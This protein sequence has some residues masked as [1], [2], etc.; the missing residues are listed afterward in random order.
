MESDIPR[1]PGCIQGIVVAGLLFYATGTLAAAIAGGAIPELATGRWRMALLFILA[2]SL[3]AGIVA[4]LTRRN[5]GWAPTAGLAAGLF[6]IGGYL[7]LEVAIHALLNTPNLAALVRLA[8][9]SGYIVLLGSL[10]PFLAG[11]PRRSLGQSLAL[12]R[13]RASTFLL[14]LALT[15]LLTLPWPLT[16]ALGD[17]LT[18][19]ELA[20]QTL[21][22]AIPLLLLFWGLLFDLLTPAMPS[23]WMAAGLVIL[24]Y[25]GTA[26]AGRILPAGSWSE[27]P[28]SLLPFPLALLLTELRAREG[29]L[30]PLLPL[31]FAFRLAPLLFTDPRDILANGIPEPQHL[32]AYGIT[33]GGG[34]LLGLLLWGVRRLLLRVGRPPSSSLALGTA[35]PAALLTWTAWGTL[36]LTLGRPGFYDDGLLVILQEQ[37][38]PSAAHTIPD[39]QTRLEYVYHTLVETAERTQAPIRAELD[40]LGVPY[41]PYYLV[42]M[43]RVDGHRWLKGHLEGLPGVAQVLVNPN[44][45]EYPNRI[46]ITDLLSSSCRQ[47]EGLLSNLAA[48]HADVAWTLGV[49]GEGIVVAGQ[50]T[51]YDWTHPALQPHYRGW[52][53]QSADHNGNWHDAWDDSA[54]PFDEDGHG[55]HTMGIIVGDDGAGDRVGVAPGARWFGCRNMRRGLG[56]PGAYIECMEFFLAPYPHGG[57]PFR[58]GDVRLAPHLVNNSW[59]CPGF[60]GCRPDTLRPAVGALRAA[61]VMMVVSAGNSGPACGTITDPPANEEAVFSVGATNSDGQVTGFSSRGPADGLVKPDIVAPGAWVRSSVPGG[62]YDCFGGTSMA[63]PHVAGTVALLW[64]ADPALIGQIERTEELLCRTADPRPVEQA[65]TPWDLEEYNPVC[66]CGGVTGVPNNVYG[67]GLLDA[68]AAVRAVLNR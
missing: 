15:A 20:G 41:R 27:S 43:V 33:L 65:C 13:F 19:L 16:G 6:A 47:P 62:G 55:T 29:G 17:R 35:I 66:A 10:L 3:P 39:R 60:E 2:L 46:P 7:A 51:G 67:C 52:D 22:W 4:L 34:V 44:V 31:A 54:E 64:S 36:Y 11:R 25:S 38:D 5:P 57:D 30:Y 14:S 40:A 26:W 50:D 53:G 45:R 24:L 18:A 8:A 1:R 68:G 49:T 9:H 58:D 42:N 37:A 32:I 21:A 56:N 59:G 63:V 12:N 61:G 23:P 48:I 28:A